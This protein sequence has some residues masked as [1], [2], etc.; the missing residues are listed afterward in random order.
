[1][2]L[3]RIAT[4]ERQE[5]R[6]RAARPVKFEKTMKMTGVWSPRPDSRSKTQEH[7]RD[8]EKLQKQI[9][10]DAE[11]DELEMRRERRKLGEVGG[12]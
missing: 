9:G 12:K 6:G 3:D 4:Q 8:G 10:W 7:K 2:L 1:M 11:K 5:E